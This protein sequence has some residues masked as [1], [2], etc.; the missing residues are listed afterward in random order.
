MFLGVLLNENLCWKKHIK[1]VKV[2]LPPKSKNK[3]SFGY[4]GYTTCL[5]KAKSRTT[6]LFTKSTQ[7]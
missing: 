1:Y 2:K 7:I 6:S 4:N 3:Y 5:T